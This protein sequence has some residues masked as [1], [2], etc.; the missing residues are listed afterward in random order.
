MSPSKVGFLSSTRGERCQEKMGV[1]RHG[2]IL[3]GTES[4]KNNPIWYK[5]YAIIGFVSI[6]TYKKCYAGTIFEFWRITAHQWSTTCSTIFCCEPTH[7]PQPTT[8][9]PN[10]HLNV[11]N[12]LAI[13]DDA[14]SLQRADQRRQ[15]IM[16]PQL[17]IGPCKASAQGPHNCWLWFLEPFATT[18][19]FERNVGLWP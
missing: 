6:P 8:H 13:S 19:K 3:C 15:R 4:T 5:T 1:D 10:N 18:S 11:G 17:P 2:F 9:N 14:L 16:A 12:W 7:N